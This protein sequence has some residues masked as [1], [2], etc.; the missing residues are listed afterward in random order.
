MQDAS[1]TQMWNA[2]AKQFGQVYVTCVLSKYLH[3]ISMR[4]HFIH[5][6]S[7]GM[8]LILSPIKATFDN[9]PYTINDE[10]WHFGIYQ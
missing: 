1:Q 4:Q 7:G 5:A 2:P 6:S 3:I 8:L 9:L 10:L